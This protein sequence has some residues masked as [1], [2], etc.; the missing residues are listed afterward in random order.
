[1]LEVLTQHWVGVQEDLL[2][3]RLEFEALKDLCH[4]HVCRLFQV[5]ET[6]L[7]YFL[8][9]EVFPSHLC[10]SCFTAPGGELFDYI[11][12]RDR[13]S[14]DEARYFF[15]QIVSAVAFLHYKGYAHRDLKPVSPP[16]LY[17]YLPGLIHRAP[18]LSK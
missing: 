7:K 15:R 4:Q 6:E 12:E 18:F 13:L 9:L 11:V 17:G 2:R 10:F 14:E 8:I 3:V 5:I 16:H 1:M